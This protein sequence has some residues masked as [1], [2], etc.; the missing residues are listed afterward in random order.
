MTTGA[1]MERPAMTRA[2]REEL[3]REWQG[4]ARGMALK[5][6]SQHRG[7]MRHA[8]EIIGD[9]TLALAKAFAKHTPSKGSFGAFASRVIQNGIVSA[10]RKLCSGMMKATFN[11]IDH[12]GSAWTKPCTY[13]MNMD[14]EAGGIGESICEDVEPR[15]FLCLEVAAI[16][17]TGI[18]EAGAAMREAISRVKS[19]LDERDR[20]VVDSLMEGKGARRLFPGNG[21]TNIAKSKRRIAK[22]FAEVFGSGLDLIA[23]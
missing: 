5:W 13:G 18:R 21:G 19:R 15:G 7:F 6:L 9:A 10:V 22:A 1:T 17:A 20:G 23:A 4:R 8:D 16:H 3:A 11:A 12:K 14:Y 2:A